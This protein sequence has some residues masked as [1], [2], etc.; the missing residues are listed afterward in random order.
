MEEP[1]VAGKSPTTRN[2]IW[3]KGL[4]IDEVFLLLFLVCVN[5]SRAK[6]DHRYPKAK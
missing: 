5:G 4:R 2:T 6:D 3:Q 1:E